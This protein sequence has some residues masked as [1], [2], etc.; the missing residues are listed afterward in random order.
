MSLKNTKIYGSVSEDFLESVADH[1]LTLPNGKV[2]TFR[3]HK[4]KVK[5]DLLLFVLGFKWSKR[6][7]KA[8]YSILSKVQRFKD[9][10]ASEGVLVRNHLKPYEV[11]DMTVYAGEIRKSYPYK[12][13][14]KDDTTI[15]MGDFKVGGE[16]KN[17]LKIGSK[18]AYEGFT[19]STVEHRTLYDNDGVVGDDD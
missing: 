17:I 11:R 1:T 8:V 2:L 7:N 16:V 14:Y 19:M 4:G 10:N 13:L 12:N 15:L 3:D 9:D 18:Q 5:V 6:N